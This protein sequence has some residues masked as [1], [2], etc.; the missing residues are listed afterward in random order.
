M[1][2]ANGTL[3]SS[4]QPAFQQRGY[5]VNARQSHMGRI[6][7]LRKNNFLM[8]VTIASKGIIA[9]PTISQNDRSRKD[10][11]TNK[12]YKAI[13]THVWDMTQSYASKAF[14]FMNLHSHYYNRFLFSMPAGHT[15]FLTTD[16]SLIDLD[17]TV[18]EVTSGSNHSSTQFVK[19]CP[20]SLVAAQTQRFLHPQRAGTKLLVAHMPRCLKPDPQRFA[21]TVKYRPCSYRGLALADSASHLLPICYPPLGPTAGRANKT[22]GPSQF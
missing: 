12:A 7:R 8:G 9:F 4:Y 17:A 19:P 10:H 22:I 11:L 5:T 18:Q 15:F 3:M 21:S 13:S 20:S 2:F 14:W 1:F 6:T 16:V